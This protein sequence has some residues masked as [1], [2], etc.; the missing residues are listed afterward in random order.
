VQDRQGWV[1]VAGVC[2]KGSVVLCWCVVIWVGAVIIELHED[3]AVF[4]VRI[5]T[6]FSHQKLTVFFFSLA[7]KTSCDK[8]ILTKRKAG[9]M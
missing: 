3:Y 2:G 8:G 4:L 7:C 6:T 1:R 9:V 5:S